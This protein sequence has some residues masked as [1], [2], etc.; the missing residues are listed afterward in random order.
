MG[1]VYEAR[2]PHLNRTVAIKVLSVGQAL[3]GSDR[4][5]AIERFQREGRATAGLA[6]PNIVQ[7]YDVG[8][9]QGLSFIV[10]ELCEGTSLRDVLRFEHHV[11][12]A[13]VR[14]IAEQLLS[15]LDAAHSR[16][17]VHRDVKPE[18][19]IV[20]RGDRIKLMDFG[21]AKVLT[22][23]TMT[24][25]GQ[26]L[27]SPAYMSPEQIL[28]KPVDARS[29]IFSAGVVLYEC[30]TGQ[31]PFDGDSITSV[32]Y[33]ITSANPPPMTGVTP[34]WHNIVFRAL[35]K[36]PAARFQTASQML[37]ALQ[38]GTA[39]PPPRAAAQQT[40]LGQ[41]Q[42]GVSR[43]TFV[44][45]GQPQQVAGTQFVTPYAAVPG[46]PPSHGRP[47]GFPSATSVRPDRALTVLGCGLIG[48]LCVLPLSMTGFTIGATAAVSLAFNLPFSIAAVAM[49]A[50]D[51][52][53]MGAGIMDR[54]GYGLTSMGMVCGIIGT[55]LGLIYLLM[56]L[57]GLLLYLQLREYLG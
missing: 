12:E 3:Q 53:A 41:Q 20:G 51:R 10:M 55:A 9:H 29:D 23:G 40:G 27:G 15:A 45:P 1:V 56:I 49:G 31:K 6:H 48:M 44:T 14:A 7:V 4:R 24:Q 32:A 47:A 39:A 52:R 37:T 54:S 5:Q 42:P 26:T 17:I 16:N 8:Q 36:D 34:L 25:A 35:A 2:D 50:S 13:R 21:I 28:G 11:P 33:K 18:N 43:T 22:D 30:L 57:L 46:P 19:I 38:T